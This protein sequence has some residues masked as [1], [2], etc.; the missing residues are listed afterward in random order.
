[1][2]GAR[3]CIRTLLAVLL[4]L[5]GLA[6]LA[7]GQSESRRHILVLDVQDAIGPASA[8]FI[9]LG[10]DRAANQNAALLILRMDTPGGLE[11]S[12]RD[13][14][15]DILASPVPV[16]TYVAP[17]GARAASAGTYILYASHIAAMTPGTN[18][19]AATPIN[20][21]G[22]PT[23]LPGGGQPPAK[24]EDGEEKPATPAKEDAASAKAINDSAAYIESLAEL[25][26]RNAEWAVK[27]VRE[28]ASLPASKALEINVID[29][30]ANDVPQLI[31]ALE[32]RS[33]TVAGASHVLNLAGLP[34]ETLEPSWRI[35]LL[36][37]ITN[38]NIALL[39]MMVG[40]YGLILEFYNPG[41]LIAGTVGGI[42]L[43]L[44][45]YA[46]NV[47]PVNFAGVALIILGL[48]L[49]VA[50]AFT[51]SFG[52]LGL[53]GGAAFIIGATMLFKT[54]APEF[55]V[56]IPFIITAIVLLGGLVILLLTLGIRAQ[57]RPIAAGEE[58]A[59]GTPAKVIDWTG[60]SGTVNYRGE[61]WHAEGPPGL[62]VGQDVV[63]AGRSGLTLDVT[64]R[65]LKGD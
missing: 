59:V 5:M 41:T 24:K 3:I 22:P 17:S 51:P 65:I 21:Q 13:I 10:I 47:L 42:S 20:L 1:M 28:A 25:R 34:V 54:D 48:V 4:L 16:A 35:K 29:L 58:T 62:S 52:M 9:S 2:S 11:T 50:E 26:G 53:G 57:R 39:L 40:V 46:L 31:E 61:R 38:P 64:P 14:I 6:G 15:R 45:L 32:G 7:V 60:T 33:V 44:G 27:A 23:G 36:A 43:L 12:M 8:E 56:S 49:I 19:G 55:Q 37:I 18:L 30:I 63:I